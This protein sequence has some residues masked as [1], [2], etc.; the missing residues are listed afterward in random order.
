[1]TIDTL[2]AHATRARALHETSSTPVRDDRPQRVDYDNH[3]EPTV[4][5]DH[6]FDDPSSPDR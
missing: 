1:M 3:G 6:P 5:N 4:D 2:E